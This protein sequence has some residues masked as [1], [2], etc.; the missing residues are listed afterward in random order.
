MSA[1]DEVGSTEWSH[2]QPV[3][4]VESGRATWFSLW[5]AE[6]LRA[7]GAFEWVTFLYL[8]WLCVLLTVFHPN[9]PHAA[10]YLG[11]HLAI[12]AAIVWLA[13]AAQRS[14][15]ATL[16]FARHWY[17]LP[18]YTFLF[19]ELGQLVHAIFPGWFDRPFLAFDYNLAGV[20]PS[21]WL[22][23]FASP[24]LNDFMQFAYMTYFAYLVVLPAM[25]YAR[26]EQLPF[27]TVMVSTAIAHYSVYV[28]SILLPV[29]SPYFSLASLNTQPLSGGFA[30][31][32]ISLIERVA[33]VHG[34]AFPSAHVAGSM[35]AL[36]ASWRYRRWLFWTTLPFFVS[37]SVATVYGRYHYVA[38]VLAGFVVGGIGFFAG[39]WL[40]GKKG[41]LPTVPPPLAESGMTVVPV[42]GF[43]VGAC[44]DEQASFAPSGSDQLQ[45]NGQAL[46]REPARNRNRGK[47]GHIRGPR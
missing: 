18:L 17:P 22:T 43:F 27:W 4:S 28:I 2:P 5:I 10:R 36:L 33:R 34:A 11:V 6:T 9:I 38:D 21:V 31:A 40:L 3:P 1:R 46:R 39:V 7:M 15:I 12:A 23:Q 35:V 20:H 25:L 41:A 37:M 8:S 19:E 32:L 47:A 24:A 26:G 16:R 14:E 45:A 44:Q 29:E 30:T 13:R 42:G